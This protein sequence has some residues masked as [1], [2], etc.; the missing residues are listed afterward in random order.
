ME[1]KVK[2]SG[3]ILYVLAFCSLFCTFISMHFTLVCIWLCL[4]RHMLR[5]METVVYNGHKM[6]QEHQW[7][8]F[9]WINV[10]LICIDH[11]NSCKAILYLCYREWTRR[12]FIMVRESIPCWS[13]VMVRTEIGLRDADQHKELKNWKTKSQNKPK[14]K[15]VGQQKVIKQ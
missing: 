2:I 12:R 10:T 6:T 5:W 7:R 9:P 13:S 15:L 3:L 11:H 8:G 4:I 1:N 14:K